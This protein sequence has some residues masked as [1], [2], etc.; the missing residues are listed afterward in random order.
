M[1][2]WVDDRPDNSVVFGIGP[3]A[4]IINT[5][6]GQARVMSVARRAVLLRVFAD[7]LVALSRLAL[8]V[9]AAR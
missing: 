8:H 5:N 7:I 6:L 9:K 1:W 4:D 3:A 2:V